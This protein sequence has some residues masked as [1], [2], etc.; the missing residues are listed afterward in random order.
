[1]IPI[2]IVNLIH[3]HCPGNVHIFPQ[4]LLKVLLFK[5]L[6]KRISQ[7]T[8]DLIPNQPHFILMGIS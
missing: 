2:E 7:S 3:L 8:I 6:L 1:M 5:N 4:I